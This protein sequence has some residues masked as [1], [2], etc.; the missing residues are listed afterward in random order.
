MP[1]ADTAL[2]KE[3]LVRVLARPGTRRFSSCLARQALPSRSPSAHAVLAVGALIRS[4]VL[5]RH[6]PD[7]LS[8]EWEKLESGDDGAA[9]RPG[10]RSGA[11]EDFPDF[12]RDDFGGV[13]L[14]QEGNVLRHALSPIEALVGVA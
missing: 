3:S 14:P 10:V 7:A 8:S 5:D 12:L 6:H 9:S 11:I 13:R 2:R 4:A 1:T